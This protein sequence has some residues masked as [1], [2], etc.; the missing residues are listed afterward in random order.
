MIINMYFYEKHR[1]FE[2]KSAK[3]DLYTQQDDN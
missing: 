1:I 2:K 3:S